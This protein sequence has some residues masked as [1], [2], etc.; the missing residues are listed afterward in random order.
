[1][2]KTILGLKKNIRVYITLHSY[3]EQIFPFKINGGV[4]SL[5]VANLMHVGQLWLTSWG[6][7]KKPPSD[8]DKITALANL[9]AAAVKVSCHKVQLSR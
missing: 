8:I 5:Y 4:I 7:T 3:G 9:G 6:Y 2:E 1:V